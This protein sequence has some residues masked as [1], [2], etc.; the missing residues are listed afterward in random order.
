MTYKAAF[1]PFFLLALLLTGCSKNSADYEK[2]DYEETKKMVVDI[3]K[4]DDGKKAI[5]EVLS[6]DQVKNEMVM[7]QKTVK[8]A[9]EQNLTSDKAKQFWEKLFKDPKFVSKYAKSLETEHKKVLKDLMKDPDYQKLILQA[10]KDP[11]MQKEIL[12]QLKS[13][14]MREEIKKVLLE[15][16]DSPLVKVKLEELLIKAAEELPAEKKKKEGTTSGNKS[17]SQNSTQK[18]TGGGQ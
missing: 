10:L 13:K 17:Q 16:M 9:I 2:V 18:Q 15:T 4:T 5:Q 1:I 8:D 6:S 11:E 12:N 3:L 14:S 7:D